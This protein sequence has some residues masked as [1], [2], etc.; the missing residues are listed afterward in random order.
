V[1]SEVISFGKNFSNV[2]IFTSFQLC[3]QMP[4][5]VRRISYCIWP[6]HWPPFW[7]TFSACLCLIQSCT[8]QERRTPIWELL[9]TGLLMKVQGYPAFTFNAQLASSSSLAIVSTQL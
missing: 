7:K 8:S 2:A 9:T 1:A 3:P 6:F 4:T 5:P